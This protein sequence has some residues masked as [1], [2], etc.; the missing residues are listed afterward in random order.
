MK[1]IIALL[2]A[3]ASVVSISACSFKELTPEEK[4]SKRAEKESEYAAEVS[5]QEAAIVG[6][7]DEVLDELGNS[8]KG[9]KL[10]MRNYN[11][12]DGTERFREIY[13]DKNGFADYMLTYCF[14]P[15]SNY[16][17]IKGQGDKGNNKLVKHDDD[18]RLIVYKKSY[19]KA[20]EGF[21][22]TYDEL[23]KSFKETTA[24]EIIE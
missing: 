4:A 17:V 7:K 10:V 24:W 8:K 5:S 1:K 15:E 18:L 19:K 20:Y 14:Y 2:L 12:S 9:K 6:A 22:L 3:L 23:V 13:F 21:D 11:K 16:Y